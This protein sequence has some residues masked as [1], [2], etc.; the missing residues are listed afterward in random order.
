[1]VDLTDYGVTTK[2]RVRKRRSINLGYRTVG[3]IG[4]DLQNQVKCYVSERD[5]EEHLHHAEDPWY[6]FPFEG[7]AYG[8]SVELFNHLY[9]AG[10]GRVYIVETDT[11]AVHHFSFK[12]FVDGHPIN[13][14]DEADGRGYEKDFQKVVPR[15]EA[16]ETWNDAYPGL[17]AKQAV[18]E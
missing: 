1:M 14:E 12:Q 10:V 8:L 9:E 7:D 15:S 17:Y 2:P 18:F 16:V 11:G 13:Y 5:T 6:D 3:N 4:H